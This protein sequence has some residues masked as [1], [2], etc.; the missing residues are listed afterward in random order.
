VRYESHCSANRVKKSDRTCASVAFESGNVF[1][2]TWC[3]C[4]ISERNFT[5]DTKTNTGPLAPE[6]LVETCISCLFN[7]IQNINKSATML[8]FRNRLI[9]ILANWLHKSVWVDDRKTW[10]AYFYPAGPGYDAH[11]VKSSV[12][13]VLRPGRVH[14]MQVNQR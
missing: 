6:A 8:R 3:L 2:K 5:R 11:L 12:S 10:R 13:P 7:I 4:G 9:F 14:L 1:K